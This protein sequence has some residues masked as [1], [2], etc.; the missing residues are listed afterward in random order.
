MKPLSL[1]FFALVLLSANLRAQQPT[2]FIVQ[3][4]VEYEKKVNM[5]AFMEEGFWAEQMRGKLPQFRTTYYDLVFDTGKSV[6]KAGRE[7]EDKYKNFWGSADGDDVKYTNLATGQTT[8]LKNVFENK[9]LLQDS[10]LN[11]EWRITP[12]TRTIAGFECRKAVGRFMDT[13]YV[14]AFF[15]DQI[16]SSAGPESFNGLPGLVLGAAFPRLHTT[17]FATKLELKQVTP[18]E[19]VAPAKGKKA[20]RA[21]ILKTVRDAVKDWGAENQRIW[22]EAII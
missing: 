11:I 17:W 10:L 1:L 8:Q 21:D 20:T 19:L 4:K 7:V 14:V 12:E 18:A 6:Y 5:Y 2:Q 15:T 9:Y 16:L 22:I 3:G 13:L